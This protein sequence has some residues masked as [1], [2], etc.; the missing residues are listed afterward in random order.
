MAPCVTV[1]WWRRWRWWGLTGF[2]CSRARIPLTFCKGNDYF[3]WCKDLLKLFIKIV[4]IWGRRE[5]IYIYNEGRL[6]TSG[7]WKEGPVWY[8]VKW[9]VNI[10][11]W[12]FPLLKGNLYFCRN[13]LRLFSAVRPDDQNWVYFLVNC[14]VRHYYVVI[15]RKISPDSREVDRAF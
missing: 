10:F 14:L 12:M 3:W 8:D 13:V 1:A 7:R 4:E 9:L 15:L 6:S 5:G 11:P 2:P